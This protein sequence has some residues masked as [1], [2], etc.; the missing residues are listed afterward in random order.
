VNDVLTTGAPPEL[1]EALE[2][3]AGRF[4][5]KYRGLVKKTTDPLGLGRLQALVPEV[6]G[7]VPTGWALPCAPYAGT[8]VGLFTIPPVGAGVWIEFEA[9]DV[10]RPVWAGTWWGKGDVPRD[11]QGATAQPK[12]KILRSEAG[13]IISLDD[14]AQ[15][16]TLSDSGSKNIVAIRAVD[17]TVE[18]KSEVNVLIEAPLI[19]HGKDAAHPPVF[20]DDLLSFLTDFVTA[21][22][23]HLHPGQT[24]AGVPV[25]PTPPGP[26]PFLPPT[27]SLLSQKNVI[28]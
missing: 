3:Q 9:G 20:G 28:E 13:L 7:D 11:E 26:N 18:I 21:F 27:P 22:N 1:T 25:T 15:T 2:R 16:I 14:E 19:Q 8:G 24:V 17:G 12:T 6:L 4:Y 10:S 23:K 5:G